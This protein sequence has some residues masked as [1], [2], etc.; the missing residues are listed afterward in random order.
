MGLF[1]KKERISLTEFV[2]RIGASLE[3]ERRT[4]D[5]GVFSKL[6]PFEEQAREEFLVLDAFCVWRVVADAAMLLPDMSRH[7]LADACANAFTGSVAEHIT[8]VDT[9][10]RLDIVRS[11][12]GHYQEAC[13]QWVAEMESDRAKETLPFRPIF[14]A[15]ASFVA[16]SFDAFPKEFGGTP[17]HYDGLCRKVHVV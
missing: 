11:R 17:R 2:T 7:A 1:S 13:S 6:A 10:D 16:G 15:Y 8:S 14:V 5:I 4:F 3:C 12:F 9:N